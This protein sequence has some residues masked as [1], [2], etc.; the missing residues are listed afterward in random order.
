MVFDGLTALKLGV[1]IERRKSV[2]SLIFEARK[3]SDSDSEL[4]LIPDYQAA[5]QFGEL[6]Y[7]EAKYDLN[8]LSPRDKQQIRRTREVV[9]QEG[10]N[11][12]VLG[13][14]QENADGYVDTT[15]L[16][17]RYS[18]LEV[19]AERRTSAIELLIADGPRTLREYRASAVKA[20]VPVSLLYYL[21][22]HD[23]LPLMYERFELEEIRRCRA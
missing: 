3:F 21:L 7:I 18:Q 14:V 15:L 23:D 4:G 16:L 13:F 19:S 12:E 1:V 8:E 10:C 20:G 5:T 6:S 9:E 22:Y 2:T 11:Y 17:R